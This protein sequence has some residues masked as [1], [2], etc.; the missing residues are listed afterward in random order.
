GYTRLLG[1][2]AELRDIG[3]PIYFFIGNHD[4]WMF[5]YLDQEMGIPIYRQPIQRAIDGKTFFIGHGD[6]LGPGDHGYK[7][8]KSI[9][10]NRLCQWLFARIHPNLGIRIMKYVSGR[11]RHTH[12][13]EDAFLGVDKEWLVQFCETT[14]KN[15]DIDFFVFGHRH[16]PIEHQL[17][18]GHSTYYNLGD[19]LKYFTY[20]EVEDGIPSLKTFE[21][22]SPSATV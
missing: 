12:D 9:F 17:S 14:I 8:I 4:M 5:R 3:I 7:M 1:K 2:L 6:G 18:N 16:L 13:V 19:W 20:L 10:S 11:S 21:E 15:K 22:S